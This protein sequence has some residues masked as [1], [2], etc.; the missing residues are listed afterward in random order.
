M[1]PDK[2][3]YRPGDQVTLHAPEASGVLLYELG[4]LVATLP[5]EDGLAR[6]TAPAVEARSPRGFRAE[7]VDGEG[8]T[9]SSTAFDV[10][11]HWSVAPRYGFLSEFTPA[12]TA[13]AVEAMNR[14][15]INV[16]QFYDWMYTHYQFFAPEEE[17]IDPLGRSTS[18]RVVRERVEACHRFGMAALAYGALYGGEKAIAEQHPEWLLYDGNGR[19]CSLGDFF[20]IQNV[21]KGCGWRELILGEFEAAVERLGFDGI[22]IDQYGFPKRGLYRPAPGEERLVDMT[23]AM[24]DF[25]SEAG[26]RIKALRPDGGNIFNCVNNWPV[27]AVAPLTEDAA[28]Y[29]EVWAPNETY[30]DLHDLVRH[31]R[32]AGPHKQ[33]ILAAYL[34]AFHREHDR[35]AGAI[36]TLRLA[37]AAI[38]ASGG[39]HLLLGEGDGVLA[40]G[41][42]PRF[43]R[44]S[45][46]DMAL[47]QRYCDFVVACG[48]LL[49]DMDLRDVS[50]T[51]NGGINDE[52]KYHGPVPF[53]PMAEPGTVWTLQHE[54]P[55]RRVLHLINLTGLG[56]TRWNAEQGVPLPVEGVVIELQVASPVRAVWCASP[57][58][59]GGPLR[60]D[61]EPVHDGRPYLRVTL[62]TLQ[63]W[64]MVWTEE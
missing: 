36:N 10:A 44:L 13:E 17:F 21:E 20:F 55:G 16:V 45:A 14:L 39:F 46:E 52:T 38:H 22:H 50:Y 3:Q 19:P 57:D 23:L 15:H 25:V 2:A 41:Y 47:V 53:S 31:A 33:V 37:T 4:R 49:H 62:P 27:E 63:Y 32:A 58:R 56:H 8:N 26:R 7:A 11:R 59:E 9:L 60:L 1:W 35:P 61:A 34:H 54:R 43:G 18:H 6:W 64:T 29:I 42:Y 40:E 48:E 5:V 24:A 51:W 30:R 12:D 28:T